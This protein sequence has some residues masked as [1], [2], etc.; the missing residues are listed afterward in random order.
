MVKLKGEISFGD[1]VMLAAD[2]NVIQVRYPS[3]TTINATDFVRYGAD[4]SFV[5]YTFSSMIDI[6]PP[7]LENHY[8]V[9]LADGKIIGVN[10]IIRGCTLNF[11]NHPFNIDLIPVLLVPFGREMLIFQGNRDNQKKESR[12]NIISCT[13]AQ[14]C[15]SKGCDIFLAHI[16]T[17]EAEDK[18]EEMRLEDVPIVRNFPEVFSETLTGISPPTRQ[19]E[20]QIDLVPGVA[21][22]AWVPYRLAPSEMKEPAEQLQE[23]SSGIY[24]SHSLHLGRP[25]LFCQDERKDVPYV[26]SII[27]V[28][29]TRILTYDQEIRQFLGTSTVT[30]SIHEGFSKIGGGQATMT[31]LTQKNVKFDWGEKEEAAFQL[32][33]Q[34]LCSAPILA[35]PKGSENFIIYCDAS[36][37]GLGAVL[38]QNKKVIGLAFSTADESTRK[39]SNS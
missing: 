13:K 7:S 36:H 8:D 12:L 20:F 14:E 29:T 39:T 31:K 18:S 34:K 10:T 38:M 22:V 17:K 26:E 35:L 15:L 1:E 5:S 9:E 6:I 19:V 27:G 2:S 24:K 32:I 16:T 37:K 25:V 28:C 23:L 11:M 4:R 3:Q 21:P 30:M 33:K